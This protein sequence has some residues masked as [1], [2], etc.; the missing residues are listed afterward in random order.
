VW[1]KGKG[2]KEKRREEGKGGRE[3]DVSVDLLTRLSRTF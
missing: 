3:R 1:E 2:E